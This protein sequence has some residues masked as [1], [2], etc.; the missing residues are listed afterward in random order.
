M[1]TAPNALNAGAKRSDV[2]NGHASMLL[3]GEGREATEQ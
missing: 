3:L 1:P 2:P